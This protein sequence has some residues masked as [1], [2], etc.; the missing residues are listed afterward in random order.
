M[1]EKIREFYNRYSIPEENRYDSYASSVV[2]LNVIFK[3]MSVFCLV[4]TVF[5][6]LSN[7]MAS[8]MGGNIRVYYVLFA[9]SMLIGLYAT[10][11]WKSH[12]GHNKARDMKVAKIIL[13][14]TALFFGLLTV[15]EAFTFDNPHNVIAICVIITLTV[16]FLVEINPIMYSGLLFLVITFN[17][18]HL[19]AV[20]NNVSMLVNSYL[21]LAV[22]SYASYSFMTKEVRRLKAEKELKKYTEKIEF[23]AKEE[24]EKRLQIQ[25][26]IIYSM[27]DLVENRDIDTG[28]HIKRTALL[29]E[30]IA[31]K[32]RELGYYEDEIT[33][34]FI[35]YLRKA[36]PMHDIGKIVIPDSILKAPRR[37][38]KEEFEIMKTHTDRGA[39]IIE[40][41]FV[42]IEEED[43][44]S[45][46]ANIARFHH[47]WWNGQ[48][49]PCGIKGADIPLVARIAAIAD[50]FDAL[51]S[52]RCYKKAYSITDAFDIMK[53]EKS[54]HFD[55]KLLDAFFK[56]KHDI[57][58]I[59]SD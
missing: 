13:V 34:E 58:K 22:A 52:Y 28:A 10:S 27:A 37:L 49:Y 18:P 5:T 30:V 45:Y 59:I 29:A 43:Y 2:K 4:E 21:F 40:N 32:A 24:T 1:F 36:M 9:V 41:I 33:D 55:P 6:F 15:Y 3:A 20:Y 48:G 35:S 14:C 50:V 47:E 19:Y 12:K 39:E 54:T 17:I 57:I 25:D 23:K 42:N 44:I 8:E 31:V 46:A 56:A 16:L 11:Y 38:T 51:V 7:K 26:D 53:K